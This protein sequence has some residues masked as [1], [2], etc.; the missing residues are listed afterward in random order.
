MVKQKG[1]HLVKKIT[2]W[3]SLDLKPSPVN[4]RAA[5]RWPE[6]ASAARLLLA[7]SIAEGGMRLT[8]P[9]YGYFTHFLSLS[10]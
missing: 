10:E 5:S 9:P 4:H 8:F 6:Q 7:T 3:P 1:V 2:S